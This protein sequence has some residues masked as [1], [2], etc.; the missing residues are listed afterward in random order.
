VVAASPATGVNTITREGLA[1]V[2][3]GT[4]VVVDAANSPSF[5]YHDALEFFRNS[6]RNLMAAEKAAGVRHHL[7]LSVV[8]AERL[9]ESGYFQ[10]KLVQENL[11]KASGIPYTILHSTQF[12][13]FIGRI[14]ESG[15][16]NGEIHLSPALMQPIASDDVVAALAE[17]AVGPPLNTTVEV[18]GPDTGPLFEFAGRLLAAKGDSRRVIAD[19]SAR[20]FGAELDDRSLTPGEHPRFGPTSFDYWLRHQQ[21]N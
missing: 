11:I 17:L 21:A 4:E 12:F 7:A 6:G 19:T 18:A 13:E 16:V 10:A 9:P 8:G 5:E 14:A 20:Y 3:V 2:L 15:A 1:E